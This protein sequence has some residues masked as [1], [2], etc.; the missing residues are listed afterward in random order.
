MRGDR[1]EKEDKRGKSFCIFLRGKVI[2][3]SL[4]FL[5]IPILDTLVCM[6][7]QGD[8]TAF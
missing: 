7:I 5:Y 6:S 4:P 1:G 8:D 3:C 2:L